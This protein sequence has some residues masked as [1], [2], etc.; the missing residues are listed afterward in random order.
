MTVI[1]ERERPSD[2]PFIEKVW[3]VQ[4]ERIGDFTSTANTHS[5]IVIA[6]YE[7]KTQVTMRGPETTA[8]PAS[9]PGAGEFIGIVFRLGAFMPALPPRSIMNRNDADLPVLSGQSFWLDSS[10]WEIPDFENADVFAARLIREGLLLHDAVVGDVLDGQPPAMSPRTLQ[11]RFARA[12]GLSYKL[13]QQI[14][15]VQQAMTLLQRGSAILDTAYETG[16]FDQPHLTNAMKRFLGRTP[17]QITRTG[18][19]ENQSE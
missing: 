14:R 1:F 18:Q 6:R 11:Y 5:E 2:A 13:I 15:R 7:G 10:A 9:A 16:Y 12:T 19:L 17:A 4:G 3:Y 8:T